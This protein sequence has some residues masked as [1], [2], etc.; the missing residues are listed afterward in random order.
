MKLAHTTLCPPVTKKKKK[1]QARTGNT[2]TYVAYRDK[3]I[4]TQK[5]TETAATRRRRRRKL[6]MV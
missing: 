5:M 2:R 1:E 4:S 6:Y 3:E